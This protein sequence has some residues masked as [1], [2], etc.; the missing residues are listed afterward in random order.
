MNTCW[1]YEIMIWYGLLDFWTLVWKNQ[2]INPFFFYEF[3]SKRTL[4]GIL[5]VFG[6]FRQ[7]LKL[8]W[9]GFVV[10]SGLYGNSVWIPQIF[11]T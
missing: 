9:F 11:E 5:V 6:S 1:E 10:D 7:D 2:T 8:F 4:L 3:G